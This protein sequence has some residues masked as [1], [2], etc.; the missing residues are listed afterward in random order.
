MVYVSHLVARKR[1]GK[2]RSLLLTFWVHKIFHSPEENKVHEGNS[3][4]VNEG[5]DGCVGDERGVVIIPIAVNGIVRS[6]IRLVIV[7]GVTL[8]GSEDGCGDS[9]EDEVS[10]NQK[11]G[12]IVRSNAFMRVYIVGVDDLY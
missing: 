10:Q 1:F 7:D 3:N 4:W 5:H 2:I 11:E 6:E 9:R 12:K 8:V